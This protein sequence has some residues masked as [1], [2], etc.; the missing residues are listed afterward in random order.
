MAAGGMLSK[1]DDGCDGG[2]AASF[3]KV[4]PGVAGSEPVSLGGCQ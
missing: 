2:L 1:A 4:S 3:G